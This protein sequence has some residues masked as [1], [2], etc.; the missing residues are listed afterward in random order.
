MHLQPLSFFLGALTSTLFLFICN[1]SQ[2][3]KT[4]SELT[5]SPCDDS[6]RNSESL[7]TLQHRIRELESLLESE[8][9]K[10]QCDTPLPI[11]ILDSRDDLGYLLE[12]ESK[13]IGVEVGVQRGIFSSIVLKA[14]QGARKYYLVDLWAQQKH[15][16]D[17]ANVDQHEQEHI[18]GEARENLKRW[19]EKAIF[20]RNDSITASREFADASLDFVYLDARHDY[21]AVL[22]DL[23]AWWPKLKQSGI[24]AGH[25]L[26]DASDV[27]RW[28]VDSEG[29]RAPPYKPPELGYSNRIKGVRAAVVEFA[30]RVGRQALST[31]RETTYAS[32]MMRK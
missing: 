9:G 29:K 16:N 7:L 24:L 32:W 13:S 28:S 4:Q 17:R 5:L 1:R 3:E 12:A 23:S 31:R 6:S 26:E 18:L 22:A 8:R 14:W 15:Y 30:A 10:S 25:D 11:P 20:V 2:R 19:A 21:A 27:R